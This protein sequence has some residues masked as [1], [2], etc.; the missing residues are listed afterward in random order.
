MRS[1]LSMLRVEEKAIPEPPFRIREQAETRGWIYSKT[2]NDFSD[3]GLHD[4]SIDQAKE[5]V[6]G[7]GK[8]L[9]DETF[10]IAR[11][12]VNEHR[13]LGRTSPSWLSPIFSDLGG[14][15]I[16]RSFTL[17][18]FRSVL[19]LASDEWR[20]MILFDLYTALLV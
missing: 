12:Y 18:E 7:L 8:A 3:S 14:I 2:I 6:L 17:P 16:K 11:R 1:N 10:E 19:D 13:L 5:V 4:V 15:K 20:S 9:N